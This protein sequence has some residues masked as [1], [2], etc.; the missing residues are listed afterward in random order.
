MPIVFVWLTRAEWAEDR[1]S[2][3]KPVD[4][5][6]WADELRR[7]ERI[8]RGYTSTLDT[9]QEPDACRSRQRSSAG[10]SSPRCCDTSR[11]ECAR[12][13]RRLPARIAEFTPAEALGAAGGGGSDA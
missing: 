13:D 11:S 2:A 6:A 10:G 3:G 4:D 8:E 5:E 1:M 12:D 7:R 9:S